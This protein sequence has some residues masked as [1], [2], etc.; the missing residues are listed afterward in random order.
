M[1]GSLV[2]LK[3]GTP[4]LPFR[5]VILVIYKGDP[6]EIIAGLESGDEC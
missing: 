4:F 1:G 2:H 6:R 3:A 5:Q